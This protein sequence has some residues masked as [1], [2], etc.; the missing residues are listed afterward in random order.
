[1][2][3]FFPIDLTELPTRGLYY[4]K[5]GLELKPLDFGSAK[6][7]CAKSKE[8]SDLLL[9]KILEL[10]SNSK[11]KITSLFRA[12]FDYLLLWE[13][14]NSFQNSNLT[15]DLKCGHCNHTFEYQLPLNK[16]QFNY[17]SNKKPKE[18]VKIDGYDLEFHYPKFED[19]IINTNNRKVDLIRNTSNVDKVIPNLMDLD[20]DIFTDIYNE[21]KEWDIGV[22][23]FYSAICPNPNCRHT[24]YFD[25]NLNSFNIFPQLNIIDLI[26]SQIQIAKY[27]NFKIED[28]VPMNEFMIVQNVVKD[29]AEQENNE[30]KKSQKDSHHSFS[31]GN[32]VNKFRK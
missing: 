10:N 23:T 6:L 15:Y 28:T 20:F 24:I 9:S 18:I 16:L 31:M 14:S 19:I 4:P 27:A 12:D 30:L 1:M 21:A 3:V 5:T 11:I 32:F 8:N 7:L 29:M 26:K 13:R 25:I 22:K 2:N 17:A